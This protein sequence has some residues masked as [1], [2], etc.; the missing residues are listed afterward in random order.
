MAH[1]A[2]TLATGM[3]PS[4]AGLRWELQ[5]G[6]ALLLLLAGY[7][8]V[9]RPV[10]V[11]LA[12]QQSLLV[13]ER[14]QL[15]HDR[16]VLGTMG[17]LP[18]QLDSL[19]RELDRASARL[20]TGSLSDAMTG[21]TTHTAALARSS[22]VVLATVKPL[23]N[24]TASG[25]TTLSLEIQ[26]AGRLASSLGFLHALSSAARLISVR[27][28]RIERGTAGGRPDPAYVTFSAIIVGYRRSGP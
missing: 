14:A 21:L 23:E 15:A 12:H 25:L 22:G 2:E 17:A 24:R 1:R 5:A 4:D 10:V 11:P 19:G 26:G 27:S 18:A 20:F 9:V 16:A 6:R 28:L 8:L 13:R 3:V 7:L